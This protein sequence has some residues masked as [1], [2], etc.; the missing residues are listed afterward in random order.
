MGCRTVIFLLVAVFCLLCQ[1]SDALYRDG[2]E[3]CTVYYNKANGTFTY[4][5][6]V[7]DKQGVA[8]GYYNNTLNA[9]GWGILEVKAECTKDPCNN[10]IV[11]YGAGY[12]E[13]IL[14]S[15][16]IWQHYLNVKPF[17]IKPGE[18]ELEK[19]YRQFFA[20]QDEWTRQMIQKYGTDD[21]YWRHVSYIVSQFD[22]LHAGYKATAETAWDTDVFV[23][24]MLNAVGDMIDIRHVV[25]PSGPPDFFRF[26]RKELKQYMLANSH[27]S[28]LVKVIGGYEDLFMSHSSW[29]LY[30]ATM[31]IYKHYHLNVNDP[32]TAAHSLSFSSYPGFL[33]SLDDFYLMDSKLVLLQTTNNVY[34][35][36]LFD[37]VSP[38][39]N[40]AWQRVRI[41]N[42]MANT[43]RQWY[44]VFKKYNSG[45]YNNQYMVIDLK[46]V[47]LNKC[48]DDDALWVVEQIPG[49]VEG[50]D[51][52]PILR[53]GYWPSYNI[54]FFENIY[55]LSGYPQ[56]V[57]QHGPDFSYQL[58]PRAKIFR[59]DAG[60]VGDMNKM[61]AIMRYNDYVHDAY[62]EKNPCDTICCRGDLD[63]SSPSAIGCYDTKVADYK[64]AL[65]MTSIAINGP[66]TSHSLKPFSWTGRFA[67]S[68]HIG[69]PTT[70]NFDWIATRPKL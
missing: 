69:L 12:L 28:A 55:N 2:Y 50:Q 23:I 57:D 58:A 24:Q 14:T 21:S 42:M 18:Q 22:G 20:K 1:L 15:R 16:Q 8:Y 5:L 26:S 60:S 70:Y 13:G 19:R 46:K 48:L 6:G 67:S 51:E 34:N 68:S 59:R 36:S 65:E 64:M 38:Q 39:A 47:K 61:K 9:T 45:T 62:S 49:L 7:M 32:S 54:P 25:N 30:A 33:E 66:T 35:A 31:R 17:F 11:M 52:T 27:C 43:G 41:A 56:L 29:F 44:E 37:L 10:T 40:L 4:K 63:S 53:A 3:E